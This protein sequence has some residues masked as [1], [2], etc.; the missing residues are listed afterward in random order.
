MSCSSFHGAAA[1]GGARGGNTQ[2][3]W[4]AHVG[5]NAL[6]LLPRHGTIPLEFCRLHHRLR[7]RE[8]AGNRRSPFD[9]PPEGW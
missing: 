2:P 7:S 8:A 3:T 5:D 4:G 6:Q 1:A 9:T